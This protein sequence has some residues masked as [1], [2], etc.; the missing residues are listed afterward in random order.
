MLDRLNLFDPFGPFGPFD[1]LDL[2]LLPLLT[3]VV[4]ALL[5][6]FSKTALSGV[7]AVGVALFAAVP[8]RQGVHRRPAAPPPSAPPPPHEARSSWLRT[9]LYGLTAG[10]ATMVAN[11]GGPA[12]SLYLLASGLGML[13]FLGTAAWFF[14]L[15]N[16]F[17]LPFSIGLDLLTPDVLLLD[18]VL[19]PAV[20]LGAYLG[21]R[22]I[23]RLDRPLFTCLSLVL[24]TLSSLNLLR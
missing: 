13:G 20:L 22:C 10:F 6:G 4:A 12:M 15:V 9:V 24:T 17:K 8:P 23:H 11:A 5:A 21:R 16:A 3:L 7:A 1:R 19:L 18:A 14:F 2:G